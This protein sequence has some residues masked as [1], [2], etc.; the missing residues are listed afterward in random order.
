MVFLLSA[1]SASTVYFVAFL[2]VHR[3]SN[4]EFLKKYQQL[5]K[6]MPKDVA[7]WRSLVV[8]LK[9]IRDQMA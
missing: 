9:E 6:C 7:G 4:R 8:S 2:H 3:D 1:R 5:R